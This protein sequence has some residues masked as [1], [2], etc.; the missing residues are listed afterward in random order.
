[1]LQPITVHKEG[2]GVGDLAVRTL[3]LFVHFFFFGPRGTRD[4]DICSEE[5]IVGFSGIIRP[6]GFVA[7]NWTALLRVQLTV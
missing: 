2:S 6:E 5:N 3:D 1:M 4:T 7:E